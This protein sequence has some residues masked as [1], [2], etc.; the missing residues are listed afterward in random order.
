MKGIIIEADVEQIALEL[1]EETGWNDAQGS[2]LS[3][4]TSAAARTGYDQDIPKQRLHDTILP[5]PI[6]GEAETRCWN[7]QTESTEVVAI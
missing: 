6:S 7:V 1:L 4:E 3:P 5:K 2:D